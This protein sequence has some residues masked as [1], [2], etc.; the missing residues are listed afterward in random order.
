MEGHPRAVLSLSMKRRTGQAAYATARAVFAAAV[1]AYFRRIEVRSQDRVP[2]SGPLL[3]V[4]NHPSALTDALVLATTLPRRIH[5]L[6]MSPLFTPWIRGV[7]MRGM[8]A[9][10]VYRREDDPALTVRN[11][12]TFAAC[13]ALLDRG[14][15]VLLFPEGRSDTDRRVVQI[16]TGAAR[17]A[18]AQEQRTTARAPLTLLPVGLYFEDR[19]R[20]QSEVI[21]SVGE[22]IAL[23]PYVA[24][25]A[26]EPREA[27]VAL[28]TVIQSAIEAL[29]QVI[30]DPEAQE[31]VEELERIYLSELK[32]RGD[33]RH[34][35]EL[36]RRVAECVQYF[37]RTDPERVVAVSRQLANYGRKL[38]ALHLEDAGLRELEK[39]DRWRRSHLTRFALAAAGLPVATV[40]LVLHWLP[41]EACGWI[42]R[43]LTPHP[44]ATSSTHMAAGILIFPLWLLGLGVAIGRLTGW[45]VPQVGLAVVLAAGL[46]I[47]AAAYFDWWE[48][49]P[50][51]LRLP[52]LAIRRRRMLV[53][54]RL[55]R[56]ELLRAFDQAREDFLTATA[57]DARR[58]V[59]PGP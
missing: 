54:V 50:G 33:P 37:R 40:G 27:V 18:I 24:R 10:P 12:T 56:N 13:H 49:Q 39:S 38:R 29:I 21:L 16:K 31:L 5:F 55:E 19:T 8:G 52:L 7:L 34:E 4:A 28:T 43:H 48:R 53:R 35:L 57:A 23:A 3:I 11:E 44:T 59:A 22:P 17:L 2:R 9:L 47:F 14:G 6:A 58:G 15:A 46:G 30:P 42:A 1:R 26:A 41:Y 36:R 20:F 51:L 25:A 45:P 32:A